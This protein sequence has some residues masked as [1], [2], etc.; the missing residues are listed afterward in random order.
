MLIKTESVNEIYSSIDYYY[1]FLIDIN[2]KTLNE[3]KDYWV[4]L[5]Y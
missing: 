1:W 3:S 2:T 5:N 4:N